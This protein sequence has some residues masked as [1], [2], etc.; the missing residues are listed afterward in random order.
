MSKKKGKSDAK[1]YMFEIGKAIAE[2]AKLAESGI[3]RGEYCEITKEIDDNNVQIKLT[4]NDVYNK[5]RPFIVPRKSIS[6]AD[7]KE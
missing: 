4:D 6:E 5:G 3:F 7:R 2:G 1:K